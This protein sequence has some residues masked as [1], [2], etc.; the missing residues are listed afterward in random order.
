MATYISECAICGHEEKGIS[1]ISADTKIKTHRSFGCRPGD[2]HDRAEDRIA[3]MAWALDQASLYTKQ[4]L[5]SMNELTGDPDNLTTTNLDHVLQG[6]EKLEKNMERIQ[7]DFAK[8][9]AP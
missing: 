4:S 2:V 3:S 7:K 8:I 1:R 9:P 6:L 5:D